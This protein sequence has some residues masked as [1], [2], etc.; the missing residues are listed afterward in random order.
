M[1]MNEFQQGFIS[2]KD[3][4]MGEL[5]VNT[6]TESVNAPA[7]VFSTFT[8]RFYRGFIW[9]YEGDGV[10]YIYALCYTGIDSMSVKYLV[11]INTIIDHSTDVP[12][13]EYIDHVISSR[14][15]DG[16]ISETF[17]TIESY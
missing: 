11:L 14:S 3:S 12:V 17:R 13:R 16:V 8:Q 9:I 1:N 5:I 2:L 15:T 7:F 6:S 10:H 4:S